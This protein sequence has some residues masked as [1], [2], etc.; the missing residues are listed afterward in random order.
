[1]QSLVV[2]ATMAAAACGRYGFD[3]ADPL[4]TSPG[5][6]RKQVTITAFAP[7]TDMVVSVAI[8]DSELAA[9]ALPDGT[10]LVFVDR[11]GAVLAH[12]LVAYR[13]GALEAWVRV[14]TLAAPTTLLWM[15]YG[16]EPA[17]PAS[18]W[19]GYRAVWHLDE[20][21]PV[22][23]DRSSHANTLVSPSSTITPAPA[24]GISGAGRA[25]DG[26]DD[27]MVASDPLDGSLDFGRD[28]FTVSAWVLV[29]SSAGIYDHI[30]HKG[31][32][33]ASVPG[34]DIE[35][36]SADWNA[37]VGDGLRNLAV[38]FG[39]E[40]EFLGSWAFV[41]MVV[42]R[43]ANTVRAYVNGLEADTVDISGIGSLDNSL[44]FT[45]S[46]TANYPFKGVMDEVRVYGGLMSPQRIA[47]E[48][49]NLVAPAS[50]VSVGPEEDAS[51][52]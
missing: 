28:S 14:P 15:Y 49:T 20:T 27:L 37:N 26:V 43:P 19:G 6:Y 30:L 12:E 41:A 39:D 50:V 36:G 35:L 18:P 40:G 21:G 46:R 51:S 7:L 31:G 5:T 22:E 24:M 1:M 45:L 52:P 17:Q 29:T 23:R 25:F 47:A 8:V 42:D 34:Y 11:D 3:T 13:D 9:H 10:D 2:L 32:S 44:D 38:R 33:N 16:G 48:Y 4:T